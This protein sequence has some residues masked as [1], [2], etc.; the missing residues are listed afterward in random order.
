MLTE[1]SLGANKR[2][3]DAE[4]IR[5]LEERD[6]NV[7]QLLESRFGGSI[8]SVSRGILG[9]DSD[10]DE[11]V[12]DVLLKLWNSI[13]PRRPDNLGAYV[14]VVARN[15]AIDRYK[16]QR[17]GGRIP[18]EQ[19]E[20]LESA[21]NIGVWDIDPADKEAVAALIAQY[22][23]SVSPEKRSYFIAKFYY[24]MKE[25]EIAENAGVPEGTVSS[26]VSRMRKE[27]RKFLK[28]EGVRS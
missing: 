18:P 12:N 6:D 5:M 28:A 8:R 2:I 10:A 27:L 4:L 21:D 20:P 25:S 3:T 26:A 7:L 23:R 17:R 1:G 24:G 14:R 9:N 19:Q 15:N 13:P 16:A 22:L 11:C